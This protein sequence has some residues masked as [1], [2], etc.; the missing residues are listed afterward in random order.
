MKSV[1]SCNRVFFALWP[2]DAERAALAAWQEP[3]RELCGGR[4]M[5]PD[6][7]HTTLVFL[8]EMPVQ[9][10][11]PL[12]LA[13]QEVAFGPFELRFDGA[14]YWGHNHVVFAAPGA[15]PAALHALVHSLEQRLAVHRFR[16]ERRIYKPH[17]TLLR[18]AQWGDTPLPELPPAVW[19]ARDFVLVRSLRDEQ[20]ARYEVLAKF[21]AK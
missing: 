20:G 14:R 17:V 4:A 13:A 15:V 16:F 5:R 8:G 21:P 10:L 7:L 12:Q 9:R 1:N 6:T 19:Q 3:L 18:H 2:D 11:E